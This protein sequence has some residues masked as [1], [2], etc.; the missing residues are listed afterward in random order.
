MP[1]NKWLDLYEWLKKGA[2][3]K[4]LSATLL[5][6]LLLIL[7]V[8]AVKGQGMNETQ[9]IEGPEKQ[10]ALVELF[11]SESCSSCP[12]AERFLNRLKKKE[13][14]W[15]EFVPLEFHVDYWNHLN[16]QDQYSQKEFTQRQQ[17][18]NQVIQ[19]GVYTPQMILN[20]EDHRSWRRRGIE[21]L[22]HPK[23]G[24]LKASVNLKEGKGTIEFKAVKGVN[25]PKCFA[26]L[27]KE[28]KSQ[29]ITSGENRGKIAQHEF[30]VHELS[31]NKMIKEKGVYNCQLS[32]TKS[33]DG[34][35]HAIAFWVIN[36][37][38]LNVIQAAGAFLNKRSLQ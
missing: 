20:G 30:V 21:G 27:M 10:A 4:T 12:P 9:I 26:A 34:K 22:D 11:T 32:F 3:M 35:S 8:E 18:Y 25:Q 1:C 15:V 38:N 36:G 23:V 19:R 16:W 29:K 28:G 6:C 13:G 7:N 31:E 24:K 17:A 14:L 33:R 5:R 2:F 37:Q